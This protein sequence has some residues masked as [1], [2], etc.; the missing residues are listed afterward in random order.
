[1][2][3]AKL[4]FH[5]ANNPGGLVN[6]AVKHWI[7]TCISLGLL[8]LS[9]RFVRALYIRRYLRNHLWDVEFPR[10]PPI[11]SPTIPYVGHFISNAIS[12]QGYM[13]TLARR[14]P[15]CS[16]LSLPMMS[17]T[18]HVIIAPSLVHQVLT[19]PKVTNKFSGDVFFYGLMEKVFGDEKQLIRNMDKDILWG[20]VSKSVQGM[21][22]EGFLKPALAT[23]NEGVS[24]RASKLVTFMGGNEAKEV[25]EQ[26][27]DV[28]VTDDGTAVTASLHPLLRDFVGYLA[29]E[30]LLG[31]D[32]LQNF[33]DILPDLF[34]LDG[35]FSL[36]LSG[37]PHILVPSIEQG[38]SARSRL[39]EALREHH[40]AL[41]RQERG[42][43]P[44][45]KWTKVGE[46]SDVMKDR[47]RAF[48][49]VGDFDETKPAE[50]QGLMSA[51]GNLVVLWAL[52]VNAN[53]VTFWMVYHVFSNSDLL[54]SIRKEIKPFVGIVPQNPNHLKIDLEGLLKDCP[55]LL[56]AFLETMR[57][58][59]GA[60]VYRWIFEDFTLT[61]SA[62]DAHIFGHVHPQTYVFKKGEFIVV[63]NGTHQLD[64]RYFP[65]ATTFDAKRFWVREESEVKQPVEA[66]IEDEA[67]Q[68]ANWNSGARFQAQKL[69]DSKKTTADSRIKVDYKTMHPW[70]GG[71]TVCKGKKFAEGE[72]LTFAAAI[73]GLW[74]MERVDAKGNVMKGWGKHPGHKGGSGAVVPETNVVVKIKRRS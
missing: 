22:R 14:Y 65:R 13:N 31:P 51:I 47:I 19:S 10:P 72:V 12:Y 5:E 16:A 58:E 43:D 42:Q 54:A 26:A 39:L 15:T 7:T 27:A 32:F 63:P 4:L 56:G 28:K 8:Y 49:K 25:W 40:I 74:D 64:E 66:D 68:E 6:F 61:E 2:A 30:I 45:P 50:E 38:I 21:M 17:S 23:L 18:H 71:P 3:I 35:T 48:A 36:L 37:L 44:G 55:L 62:E 41:M 59:S 20:P 67:A 11:I 9:Y 73:F 29:I 1:M 33:P 46:T 57:W 52:N 24:A 60:T 34:G 70:G 53:Q 69:S